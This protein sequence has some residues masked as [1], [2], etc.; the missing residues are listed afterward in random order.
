[1]GLAIP[2]V[3][4]FLPFADSPS[5]RFHFSYNSYDDRTREPLHA[6]DPAEPWCV[7]GDSHANGLGVDDADRLSEVLEKELISKGRNVVVFNVASPGTTLPHYVGMINRC[8]SIYRARTIIAVVYL[9][10]DLVELAH[11]IDEGRPD[12]SRDTN[13]VSAP[14]RVERVLRRFYVFDAAAF[15]WHSVARHRVDSRGADDNL[16]AYAQA[17]FYHSNPDR[18]AAD[19]AVFDAELHEMQSAASSNR[20]HL[21]AVILPSWLQVDDRNH[22]ETALSQLEL[23]IEDLEAARISASAVTHIDAIDSLR[24]HAGEPK[25]W[26][27]D[28]HLST[29]GHHVI[30]RLISNSLSSTR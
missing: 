27:V 13:T 26:P 30:G 14:E 28:R 8:G 29:A 23:S 9:G 6:G 10:N 17:R 2:E 3:A 19:L 12:V 11:W 25:F 18:T 7:A 15:A 1:V 22:T 16:Q 21:T 5:K 20:A 24:R 4:G